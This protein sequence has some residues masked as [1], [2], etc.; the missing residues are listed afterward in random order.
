M[1]NEL[2]KEI[3]SLNQSIHKFKDYLD[4]CIANNN[5]SNVLTL[6]Q[7]CI[8]LGISRSTLLRNCQPGGR[9][10]PPLPEMVNGKTVWSMNDILACED[11]YNG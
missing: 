2:C 1:L 9:Y 4:M 7:V 5:N 11:L 6:K 10:P 8:R 3:E